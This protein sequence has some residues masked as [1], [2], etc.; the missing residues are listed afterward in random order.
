MFILL[1]VVTLAMAEIGFENS[2]VISPL[3]SGLI[4]FPWKRMIHRD[5]PKPKNV[6][7]LVGDCG[8]EEPKLCLYINIV[9][10]C[11]FI[12]GKMRAI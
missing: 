11:Y 4:P 10:C 12:H 3:C 5:P 7:I 9:V 2:Y 8:C 1:F 6:E